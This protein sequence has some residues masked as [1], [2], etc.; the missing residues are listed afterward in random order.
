MKVGKR[1]QH[2][3]RRHNKQPGR[4]RSEHTR[5]EEGHNERQQHNGRGTDGGTVRWEAVAQQEAEAAVDKEQYNSQ[6]E[7][8]RG[9][10]TR[11]EIRQSWRQH[12]VKCSTKYLNFFILCLYS[13]HPHPFHCRQR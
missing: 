5:E 13:H 7:Q 4:T 3:K 6:L 11:T 8:T 12:G 9:M 1:R 10:R 2:D